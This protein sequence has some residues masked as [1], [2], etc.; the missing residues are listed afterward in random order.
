MRALLLAVTV[1][2]AAGN[3]RAA[4]PGADA[5]LLAGSESGRAFFNEVL[6]YGWWGIVSNER[7][8]FIVSQE[9]GTFACVAWPTHHSDRS[10]MF[11]GNIPDGTVAI[12]HTHPMAWPLPSIQD[13]AEADRLGIPIYVVTPRLVTKAVPHETRAVEVARSPRW[14]TGKRDDNFHCQ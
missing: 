5:D 11:D 1:V 2:V 14:L 10:E 3:V 7:A 12:I 13:R 4:A 6:R 9:D 8:A